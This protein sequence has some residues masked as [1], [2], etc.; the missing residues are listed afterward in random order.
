MVSRSCEIF[1]TKGQTKSKWFFQ[2]DISK[3]T[4]EQIQLY[5][6]DTLGRFVFVRFLEEIEDTEKTFRNY[7]TFSLAGLLNNILFLWTSIIWK[8]EGIIWYG[9]ANT[10]EM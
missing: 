5:Y 1:C 6:Y 10:G 4:K 9:Q 7:L 2:A 3:K 8:I